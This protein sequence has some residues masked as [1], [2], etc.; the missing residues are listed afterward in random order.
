MS[1][2]NYTQA[3]L[4]LDLPEGEIEVAPAAGRI[5]LGTLE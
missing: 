4:R 2:D 1:W 3:I 5:C